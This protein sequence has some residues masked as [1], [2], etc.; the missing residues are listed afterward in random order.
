MRGCYK[1]AWLS[2]G[3]RFEYGNENK[4]VLRPGRKHTDGVVWRH[5]SGALLPAR[6]KQ[7]A[8]RG[9]RGIK[10]LKNRVTRQVTRARLERDRDTEAGEVPALPRMLAGPPTVKQWSLDAR[11]SRESRL[12]PKGKAGLAEA[13]QLWRSGSIC[14]GCPCRAGALIPCTHVSWSIVT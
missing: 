8:T 4:A 11:S 13:A 14:S 6:R 1:R 9:E 5:R 12:R 3:L 7:P 2:F 10:T